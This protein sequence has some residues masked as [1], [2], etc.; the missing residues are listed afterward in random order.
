MKKIDLQRIGLTKE[1]AA[2]AEAYTSLYPGRVSSQTKELYRVITEDGEMTAV[3]SGK[4]RFQVRTQ[5][6]Y[7]VVGDFVLVDRTDNTTG[8][9]VIHHVLPR[10]S[11]FARKE[12]GTRTRATSAYPGEPQ[13]I[14]ANIDQ[15]FLCMALNSD[16]NLRRLERYLAVAWE[17]GAVPV[18]VLTKADLCPDVE[19]KVAAL[20]PLTVG[21][22][23]LVTT[24][25]S[26]QGYAAVQSR[27]RDGQTVAFIGSSGVGKSTLINCLLGE[28]RLATAGIRDDGR[29]RHTTTRRELI[30]LPGGGVVIDTP[31]LRELGIISA[32]LGKSFADIEEL[33]ASCRF[34]DCS[35]GPEPGCAVQQAIRD[36]LL[37][38]ERLASFVKLRKEARYMEARAHG[39]NAKRIEKEKANEMFKGVGGI[40]NARK[41]AKQGKTGRGTGDG[42]RF[43]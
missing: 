22:D 39:L 42:S 29:G 15:V 4:F 34:R 20:T 5:A 33:A 3:V 9:G 7:P 32:D 1:L 38:A 24:S 27:I 12:A 23:V 28:A 43:R 21:V 2:E 40:K 10:K 31:G 17:S 26:R 30:I 25:T 13:V 16:F 11:C 6:G 41:L 18:V 14:A 36:G 19:A 37:S 8:N 35:H